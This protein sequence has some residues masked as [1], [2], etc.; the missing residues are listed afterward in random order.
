MVI[1][2]WDESLIEAM[3][4]FNEVDVQQQNFILTAVTE[5]LQLKNISTS[6]RISKF[7]SRIGFTMMIFAAVVAVLGFYLPLAGAASNVGI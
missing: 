7:L 4:V 2:D 5:T 3:Q 6:R 1:E